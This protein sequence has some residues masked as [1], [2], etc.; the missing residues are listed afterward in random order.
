MQ[1]LQEEVDAVVGFKEFVEYEDLGKLKYCG[2]VFK[3][4]LRL[5]PVAPGTARE[6]LEEVTVSGF[7]IPAHSWIIF[8]FYVIHRLQNNFDDPEEFQPER[9]STEN[10]KN[11]GCYMPFSVGHRSCIG[12]QFATME[13]KVI[14][15][16]F[17]KN[18]NY[19]LDMSQSFDILDTASLRPKGGTMVTVTPR[20]N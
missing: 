15:C 1:R 17:F 4:T 16:K 7:R 5:Y 3:E 18:F 2:Q 20:D 19:E 10:C 11:L 9:F 8:P 14:L 13:A 12:R 6:N